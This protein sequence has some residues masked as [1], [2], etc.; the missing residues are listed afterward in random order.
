MSRTVEI[1]W[2]MVITVIPWQWSLD[3]AFCNLEAVWVS[4]LAVHSSRQRTLEHLRR[5]RAR[6][7]SCLCPTENDVPDSFTSIS[8]PLPILS[9]SSFI[10]HFFRIS[11]ISFSH[12][13]S[14]GS[15][16]ALQKSI[17]HHKCIYIV[18]VICVLSC[19]NKWICI[20]I[21][22]NESR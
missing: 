4:I 3:I 1:L 16:F 10:S 12:F 15:R 9:T 19:I 6:H 7:R 5:A 18:F 8:N 11:H 21:Y 17:S 22:K 20:I 14:N 13:S 2:A